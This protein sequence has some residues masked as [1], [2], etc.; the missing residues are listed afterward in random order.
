M[1][2]CRRRTVKA[3]RCRDMVHQCTCAWSTYG[4]NNSV[5]LCPLFIFIVIVKIVY[6]W[7]LLFMRLFILSTA[8]LTLLKLLGVSSTSKEKQD[9]FHLNCQYMRLILY[10]VQ[11]LGV[12][13]SWMYSNFVETVTC[14]TD[15]WYIRAYFICNFA[16]KATTH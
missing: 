3:A 2:K 11:F 10:T 1:V 14:N 8:S 15:Q 5:L 6:T 12:I 13:Y 16:T 9:E 7:T 4:Y